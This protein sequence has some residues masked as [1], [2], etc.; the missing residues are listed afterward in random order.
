MRHVARTR[1]EPVAA[2]PKGAVTES[3]V[4]WEIESVAIRLG[5]EDIMI[6]GKAR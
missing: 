4:S 2:F 5:A 3:L 6:A 1:G